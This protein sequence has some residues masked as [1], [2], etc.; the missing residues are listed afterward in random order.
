M[1]NE[2]TISIQFYTELLYSTALAYPSTKMLCHLSSI[3][4]T[5]RPRCRYHHILSLRSGYPLATYFRSIYNE[6]NVKKKLTYLL[7]FYPVILQRFPPIVLLYIFVVPCNSI[8][9]NTYYL[10]LISHLSISSQ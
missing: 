4:Y 10:Q 9:I 6:K 5:G 8:A 3:S 7:Q 2:K 1:N